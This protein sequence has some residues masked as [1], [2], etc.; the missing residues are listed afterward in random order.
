MASRGARGSGLVWQ[1]AA[2]KCEPVLF[3]LMPG[4]GCEGNHVDGTVPLTILRL[5]HYPEVGDLRC[6]MA[7]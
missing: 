5:P 1:M 3:M 2:R 4:E 6:L 7:Q